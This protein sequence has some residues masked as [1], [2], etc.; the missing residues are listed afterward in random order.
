MKIEKNI[1]KSV[2]K[3][4]SQNTILLK[5]II[6]PDRLDCFRTSVSSDCHSMDFEWI[7]TE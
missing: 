1:Q 2:K 3:L 5:Q 7:R 6:E 4:E